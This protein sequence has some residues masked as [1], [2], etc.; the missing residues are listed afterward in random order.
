MYMLGAYA[1]H[2]DKHSEKFGCWPPHVSP[3]VEKYDS[4]SEFPRFSPWNQEAFGIGPQDLVFR[5][6][7]LS[8]QHVEL[9]TLLEKIQSAA[10][11]APNLNE[12]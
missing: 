8:Q 3:E 4:V 9:D 6:L 11:Y 2:D 10:H 5:G 1:A 12:I 7:Q